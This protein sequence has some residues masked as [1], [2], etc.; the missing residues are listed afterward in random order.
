MTVSIPLRV[1]ELACSRLC[2]DLVSP[3][4]A[5]NNGVELC[6][7]FDDEMA[8][9]ALDLVAASGRRAAA[10][11]QVFRM[12][13]GAGGGQPG[14]GAAEVRTTADAYLE[15][16]KITLDWP[17]EGPS[18]APA[19]PPGAARLF[20]LGLLVAEEALTHGGRIVP[21]FGALP[22]AIT[23]T[24]GGRQAALSADSTAALDGRL[25][26]AE[27]TPRTIIAYLVH[28]FAESLGMTVTLAAGEAELRLTLGLGRPR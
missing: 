12:A 25:D 22:T 27:L 16:S 2:H 26:A 9:E 1:L 5:V 15:G 23:L 11:L 7:E 3:V 6:Q 28:R 17:S 18:D 20:V 8:A 13:L 19:W 10:R 4:G 14:I 21:D 24:A